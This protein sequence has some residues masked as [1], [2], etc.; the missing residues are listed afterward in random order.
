MLW[1]RSFWIVVPLLC[2]VKPASARAPSAILQV[3]L[4]NW[5]APGF[6]EP[7]EA[8]RS[9]AIRSAQDSHG[10]RV[11][12]DSCDVNSGGT[13]SRD[14]ETLVLVGT[15]G[16]MLPAKASQRRKVSRVSLVLGHDSTTARTNTE[17][18]TRL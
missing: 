16:K 8:E 10:R 2:S 12:Q 15:R 5:L 6:V 11:A 1:S 13:S 18:E 7:E 17:S 9:R 4:V 3:P 14:P